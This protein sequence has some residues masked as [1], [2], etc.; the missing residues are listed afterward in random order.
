MPFDLHSTIW[1]SSCRSDGVPERVSTHRTRVSAASWKFVL[2]AILVS[3][4]AV[5]WSEL[6][7]SQPSV[8]GQTAL[9]GHTGV[10]EAVSF[11][12]DGR[13]LVSCGWDYTVRLWDLARCD[14][15]EVAEPVILS[16]TSTRF[17]TALSPDGSLLVSAG[18]RSLTI[19]TCRPE[20]RRSIERAGETYRALSFSPDGHTLALGAEDGTI[21]LWDMPT[22]HERSVLNGHPDIVRCVGFSPDGKVLVSMGQRGRVVLWDTIRGSELRVLA[23]DSPGPVRSVAFSPDGRTVA[24]GEHTWTAQDVLLMDVQTGAIRTRLTGHRR[25]VN[26]LAF[27]PDGRTLA[28]GGIDRCIKLW[29]LTT[30]K[31]V[32]TLEEDVG[33]V[34]SI[35]FSPDG[36]RMAFSGNDDSIRIRNLTRVGSQ[37]VGLP[38]VQGQGFRAGT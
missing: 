34:K 14:G 32:A 1:T 24:F 15:Q 31:E 37:V 28:T 30:A 5:A 12:P 17:A 20:F 19:W 35:A 4:S 11:S 29:D 2:A 7:G 18:D 23:T 3:T 33:W 9:A 16:H 10:V 25:G 22:A 36:G 27:S 6:S 38:V 13:T 8:P 21:R 26:V